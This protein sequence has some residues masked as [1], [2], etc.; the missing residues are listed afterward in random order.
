[1]ISR[2]G[3]EAIELTYNQ[4]KQDLLNSQNDYQIIRRGSAGSGGSAN[5]NIRAQIS[6][7]VLEIPVKEGDQ[8]IQSNNF[9]AGTTIASIADMTKTLGDSGYALTKS[10]ASANVL[11]K[12]AI[13]VN[14]VNLNN[15]NFKFARASANFVIIDN[16]SNLV[17]GELSENKR[18]GHLNYKEAA[19]ALSK[20]YPE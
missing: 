20:K 15:D 7:T 6:G 16:D 8:V 17:V 4:A 11:I 12:G 9:N 18:V 3:F 5:T 19:I 13:I 10:E 14:P 2:S 1:M